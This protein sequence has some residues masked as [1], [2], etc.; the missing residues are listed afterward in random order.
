MGDSVCSNGNSITTLS[1]IL[2]QVGSTHLILVLSVKWNEKLVWLCQ[3]C[4]ACKCKCNSRM[5][6]CLFSFLQMK[7]Q[8]SQPR[9]ICVWK[10]I[11]FQDG[12]TLRKLAGWRASRGQSRVRISAWTFAKKNSTT[13]KTYSQ[14]REDGFRTSRLS[15]CC[16]ENHQ[17]MF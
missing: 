5:I 13:V 14:H 15:L 12:C 7:I 8:R 6:V 3:S 11:C 17:K 2:P 4:D 16:P 9:S 10:N 1:K